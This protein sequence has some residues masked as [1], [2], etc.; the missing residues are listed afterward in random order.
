MLANEPNES[1][2][3]FGEWIRSLRQ[4]K[5]QSVTEMA[6]RLQALGLDSS[7]AMV[8]EFIEL[9]QQPLLAVEVMYLLRAL[10]N[11]GYLIYMG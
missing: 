3:L 9:G 4:I 6:E 10:E 8:L 7:I 1:R 11:G 5:G 2:R